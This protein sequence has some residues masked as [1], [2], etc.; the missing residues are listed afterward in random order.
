MF[1]FFGRKW[2][3]GREKFLEDIKELILHW[4]SQHL[5]HSGLQLSQVSTPNNKE[6]K[7]E[8]SHIYL[9]VLGILELPLLFI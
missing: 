4:Q 2:I 1:S 3:T 5:Q 6:E 7:N 8:K 9:P